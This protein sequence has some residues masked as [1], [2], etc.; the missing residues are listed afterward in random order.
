M[1][2]ASISIIFEN[3]KLIHGLLVV[4]CLI[5]YHYMLLKF[6][7]FNNMKT[8]KIAIVGNIV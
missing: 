3:E 8:N 4:F 2:V 1:S 7:P 6:Q 5:V